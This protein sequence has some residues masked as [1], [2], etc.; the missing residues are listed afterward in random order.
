MLRF[1][2]IG[3]MHTDIFRDSRRRLY[4]L[5]FGGRLK[6]CIAIWGSS[7]DIDPMT[8][9]ISSILQ[10]LF[11]HCILRSAYSLRCCWILLL[12]NEPMRVTVTVTEEG[13]I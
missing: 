3:D 6:K 9:H 4:I 13:M 2:S 12:S 1:E 8:T 5:Q 10:L 11:Q 7:G